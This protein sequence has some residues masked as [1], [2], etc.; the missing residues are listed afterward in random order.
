MNPE[1]DPNAYTVHLNVISGVSVKIE[2]KKIFV[3]E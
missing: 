2:V 3:L 1:E